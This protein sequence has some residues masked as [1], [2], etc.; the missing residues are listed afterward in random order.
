V[1]SATVATAFGK[2]HY[3]LEPG[4]CN[5]GP[6]EPVVA[7]EPVSRCGT[8]NKA[9]AGEQRNQQHLPHLSQAR[10]YV[11]AQYCTGV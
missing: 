2:N 1:Q 5:D 4:A 9:N 7:D 8:T 6:F 11:E 10:F 3:V